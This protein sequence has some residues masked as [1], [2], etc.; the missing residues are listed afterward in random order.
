MLV[1]NPIRATFN[2]CAI[3]GSG[4]TMRNSGHGERIDSHDTV[5]RVNRLPNAEHVVDFGRKTDIYFASRLWFQSDG[6][7]VRHLGG[8]RKKCLFTERYGF[9]ACRFKSLVMNSGNGSLE[10][11]TTWTQLY[12]IWKPGFRPAR[13]NFP[14]AHQSNYIWKAVG[15]IQSIYVKPKKI[16]SGLDAIFSFAPLCRSVELFGFTGGAA[17]DGHQIN[18]KHHNIAAEHQLLTDMLDQ[19]LLHDGTWRAAEEECSRAPRSAFCRWFPEARKLVLL[20]SSANKT[21]RVT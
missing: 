7:I 5:I 2:N 20:V 3:V 18:P 19:R 16:T 10:S 6:F 17:S 11:D 21:K 4:E 14:I 1:G 12:P 15:T 8:H 13:S 9:G